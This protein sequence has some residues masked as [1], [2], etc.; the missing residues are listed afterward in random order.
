VLDLDA[1][2]HAEHTAG[3]LIERIDGDVSAIADFFA[4]F[5][6]Q[7]LGNGV[8][9][10]GVLVLLY[11]EDWRVGALLSLFV[12]AA[13]ALMTRGGFVAVRSRVARQAAAK[14]S[15]YLE[16]RLDGLPDLKTSGADDYAMRR[17]HEHL[18]A[19][20]RTVRS[21][22]MAGSLFNGAV[23]LLF[24][25]GT[26]AALGLSVT[27][28][29]AGA[30]TLGSVYVVY[31]YTGMLR[32][33]LERL[34]RQLNSF[35]QAAGAI[36]RV[37]ELLATPSRLVDG[38]GAILPKGAL[39]VELDGVSFAYES[40]PVLRDISCCGRARRSARAARADRLRQVDDLAA[41][42]SSARPNGG[43]GATRWHRHSAYSAGFAAR[44]DRAG[45][46]GCAALPGHPA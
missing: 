25:L 36:V 44:A 6:V 9:L 46:P 16:E 28:F 40:E 29:G 39:S 27:L 3:E 26:G 34:T 15:E 5:V 37:R 42:F 4:R 8:F 35:L 2:F 1:S 23:G 12:L 22:V 14:L 45:D 43:G 38:H 33:P 32:Q 24:V 7:M 31:R 19:R 10:F 13:L 18:A 11:L 21:S 41:A 20:F 17:L 30:I